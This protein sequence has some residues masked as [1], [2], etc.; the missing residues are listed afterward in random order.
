MPTYTEDDLKNAIEA[1][2]NGKSAR[3]ASREWSVPT[4]TLH[5]RMSGCQPRQIAHEKRQRLSRHQ[6]EDLVKWATAQRELGLPPTYAQVKG[7]AQRILAVQGDL[8]PIGNHWMDRFLARNPSIR[9]RNNDARKQ[10]PLSR[11][12]RKDI[13]LAELKR[14]NEQLKAELKARLGCLR[15]SKRGKADV[16]LLD[17]TFVGTQVIPQI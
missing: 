11:K 12:A 13:E 4:T 2:A 6:E 8:Q 16:N 9:T 10:R 5:N 17:T 3:Q 7:F 1:I 15:R 14:E